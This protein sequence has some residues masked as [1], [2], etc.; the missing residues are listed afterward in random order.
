M[1]L[2]INL[3]EIKFF[4]FFSFL[5][6]ETYSVTPIFSLLYLH[7]EMT[8]G[9]HATNK[10]A[11]TPN[12]EASAHVPSPKMPL[13]EVQL[14]L[15]ETE[16]RFSPSFDLSVENNFQQIVK[17]LLEDVRQT[18]NCMPR[19][20]VDDQ[21]TFGGEEDK[22]LAEELKETDETKVHGGAG[23]LKPKKA[24]KTTTMTLIVK[25]ANGELYF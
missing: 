19:I 3:T 8:P 6:T 24:R 13:F 10:T 25:A 15:A 2:K 5:P 14:E 7:N 21:M 12:A 23:V 20:V 16:I 9:M 22:R 11:A 4:V 18:C 1:Q 17:Q